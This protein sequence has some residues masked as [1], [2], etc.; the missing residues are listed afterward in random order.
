VN[1]PNAITVVRIAVAPLIAVLVLLP[2]WNLRLIA[3]V[4]YVA[5]AV[6][7]YVDGKLARERN[8]VTDLGRLLDPLADKM[9]LLCT[10]LPTWWLMRGAPLLAAL[11]PGDTWATGTMVDPVVS[12]S[13]HLAF[14]FVT[15]IGLVGLPL[16]MVLV[17]LGRELLM[18]VFR[19]YAAR[20]G[21]IISAIGPAKWKTAFQS[22]WVGAA[23]FWFFMAQIAVDRQWMSAAWRAFAMFTGLVGTVSML[24]A[25]GLTVY[26]LALYGQRYRSVFTQPRTV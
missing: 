20:R 25:V 12:S 7:D 9:L 23:F 14:P 6:T 17:V 26:S 5:A 18:T 8:L 19:Q 2:S 24:G 21:V 13:P 10:L 22:V 15:P 3:W 16:W 4:L 11:P 1:L